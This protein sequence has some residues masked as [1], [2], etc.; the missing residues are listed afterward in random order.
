MINIKL[1]LN[2]KTRNARAFTT[3]AQRTRRIYPRSQSLENPPWWTL[4]E[5]IPKNKHLFNI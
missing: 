5:R 3:K 2:G 1:K 4:W